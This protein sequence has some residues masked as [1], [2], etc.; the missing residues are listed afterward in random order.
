MPSPD[1]FDRNRPFKDLKKLLQSRSIVLEDTD[2]AESAARPSTDSP[3]PDD[4][5]RLFEKEMS[6]VMPLRSKNRTVAH[7]DPP[8]SPSPP[9]PFD[10]E[11]DRRLRELIH[12]GRG[13]RVSDTSEYMEGTGPCVPPNMAARL[14]NGEFA[15]QA[16]LDL[17]GKTS[18]QAEESFGEFM[19]DARRSGKQGLLVI[20][21]RGL[22]SK[23]KPVLK[24]KVHHWLTRGPWR[25]WV[26]AFSSA[27]LCDGGAGATYILLRNRP[28][29]RRFK[30]SR[31][32]R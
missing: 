31:R 8:L 22:S 4:D 32:S 29:T 16:H 21:G 20:H 1:R 12:N 18:A 2:P 6:D 3:S 30:K 5:N 9:E 23:E 13:F 28:L 24:E 10:S 11:S 19:K 27:R 26:A 7:P 14:H 17:H 25:K 15:I